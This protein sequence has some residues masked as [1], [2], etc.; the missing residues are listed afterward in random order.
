[1]RKIGLILFAAVT[2][3]VAAGD[4]PGLVQWTSSELLGLDGQLAQKLS[5]QKVA[6]QPLRDFGTHSA[7]MVHRQGDGEAEVHEKVSDVFIVRSGEGTLVVGGKVIGGKN[8]E[9]GEIRGKSI[10]GGVSK[11]IA[12][13]DIINI[14][15]NTPHQTLVRPG[16]RITIFVVKVKAP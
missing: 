10:Q 16:Q 8:T 4:P 3:A 9:P 5:P 6:H 13:G 7:T 15:V 11:K 14:P 2:F 1:M 12:V